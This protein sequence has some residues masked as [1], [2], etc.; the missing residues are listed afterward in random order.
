[1]TRKCDPFHIDKHAL[2]RSINY[3]ELISMI[4]YNRRSLVPL[5]KFVPSHIE[6][7]LKVT[8]QTAAVRTDPSSHFKNLLNVLHCEKIFVAWWI[9]HIAMYVGVQLTPTLR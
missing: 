9:A 4:N 3:E 8:T 5:S 7:N 2:I 1:M 6:A